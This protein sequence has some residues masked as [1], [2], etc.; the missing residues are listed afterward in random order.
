MVDNFN[1]WNDD[2]YSESMANDNNTEMSYE[3]SFENAQDYGQNLEQ[4]YEPDYEDTNP[5]YNRDFQVDNQYDNQYN[6]DEYS[7]DENTYDENSYADEE[8]DDN[9]EAK[10]RKLNILPVIII[11]LLLLGIAGGLTW[12]FLSPKKV[13]D[14]SVPNFT[15]ETLNT[16]QDMQ[17]TENVG[18]YFFNEAGGEEE[19]NMVNVN[20]GENGDTNVVMENQDG[21]QV[22]ATVSEVPENPD[23]NKTEKQS[24]DEFFGTDSQAENNSEIMISYNKHARLNPFKP[25]ES[26]S[27]KLDGYAKI[28]NIDFEI[29]EPPVKSV[30]DENLTRLLQTQISGILYDD[31]KP[32]AIVNL[33]GTDQFVKV[34]DV[35]SGYKVEKI[36]RK[37]VQI[38]YKSNTYIASVGELFTRGALEKQRAVVNLENKFAGNRNN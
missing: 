26:I 16:E 25:L 21:E 38:S 32:A 20:F 29:L 8:E 3:T 4:D 36:T 28:N 6:D 1:Q 11:L 15:N 35:V 2:E 37:Q 18:D 17:T 5:D 23:N 19:N 13:A 9:F 10:P 12:Y 24:D 31:E 7:D 27:K 33:N 30:P 22:V 14:N 34:G